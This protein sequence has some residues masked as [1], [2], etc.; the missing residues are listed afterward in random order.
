M[1]RRTGGGGEMHFF[2]SENF[3]QK[4]CVNI[5]TGAYH[6]GFFHDIPYIYPGSRDCYTDL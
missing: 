3:L 2:R 4:L 5:Q 1:D 6:Q